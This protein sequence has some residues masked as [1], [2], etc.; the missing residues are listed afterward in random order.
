MNKKIANFVVYF[1]IYI[2]ISY[3]QIIDVFINEV[4]KINLLKQNKHKRILQINKQLHRKVLLHNN[5]NKKQAM[6]EILNYDD[7]IFFVVN[8]TSCCWC[9]VGVWRTALTCN[10]PLA[11]DA[12]PSGLW[13]PL[14]EGNN[15][16]TR[17]PFYKTLHNRGGTEVV[18][19]RHTSLPLQSRNWKKSE[20]IEK[21]NHSVVVVLN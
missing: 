10:R 5:N 13:R 20:K 14:K 2:I 11:S 19:N 1:Y 7:V 15:L 6:V 8:V 12:P 16:P 18:P 17:N 4:N 9:P 21:R 3:I